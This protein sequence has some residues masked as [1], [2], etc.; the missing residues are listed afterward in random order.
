VLQQQA[1]T[2]LSALRNAGE[3]M[4]VIK[5]KGQDRAAQKSDQG[6]LPFEISKQ[7]NTSQKNAI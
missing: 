4:D 3:G 5:S 2:Q 6:R 1:Q 7:G